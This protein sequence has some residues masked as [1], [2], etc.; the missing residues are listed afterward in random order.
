MQPWHGDEP[1]S[2]IDH[3]GNLISEVLRACEELIGS[4]GIN[5]V[6]TT[7]VD[8]SPE[9]CT[10]GEVDRP[11]SERGLSD[12]QLVPDGSRAPTPVPDAPQGNDRSGGPQRTQMGVHEPLPRF[13]GQSSGHQLRI[14]APQ[15][16]DRVR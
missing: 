13:A 16:R 7:R 15:K 9:P 5:D 2:R 3:H 1:G 11:G 10:A 6:E 8:R 4:C 12:Q 14:G